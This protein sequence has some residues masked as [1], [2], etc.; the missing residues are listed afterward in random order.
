MSIRHGT[1]TGYRYHGCRCQ[2]CTRAKRLY[3]RELRAGVRRPLVDATATREHLHALRAAGWTWRALS[4]HTGYH[5]TVLSSIARGVT[6]QVR[7]ATAADI[8]SVPVE[9]VAA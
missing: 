4:E 9:E 8:A 5:H 2:P 3:Q 6:Q 1:T 7:Q